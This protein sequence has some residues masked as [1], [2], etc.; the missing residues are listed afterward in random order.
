[1]DNNSKFSRFG[2]TCLKRRVQRSTNKQQIEKFEIM[3]LLFASNNVY[4]RKQH[5]HHIHIEEEKVLKA[6]SCALQPKKM[7]QCFTD[8]PRYGKIITLYLVHAAVHF[9]LYNAD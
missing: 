7:W 5:F 3:K 9:I 8:F 4:Q 6:H 1:M 2:T